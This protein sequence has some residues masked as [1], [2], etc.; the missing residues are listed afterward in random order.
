MTDA[1]IN[2]SAYLTLREETLVRE[3]R[4]LPTRTQN[5]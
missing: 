4:P 2:Y 5:L 1:T 3:L